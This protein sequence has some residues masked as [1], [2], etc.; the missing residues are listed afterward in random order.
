MAEL[1]SFVKVALIS[2]AFIITIDPHVPGR[3]EV[4]TPGHPAQP[5]NANCAYAR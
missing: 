1:E 5:G 3:L 4:A 2:S